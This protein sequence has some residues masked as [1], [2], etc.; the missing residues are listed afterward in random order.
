MQQSFIQ[1]SA[2]PSDLRDAITELAT[3]LA[4]ANIRYHLLKG[5][6][7][8]RAALS[9]MVLLQNNMDSLCAQAARHIP[10]Q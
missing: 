3:G 7:S 10:A 8:E 5:T 4:N 2:V 9:A 1:H 6:S